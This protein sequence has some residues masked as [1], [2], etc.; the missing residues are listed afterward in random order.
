MKSGLFALA[1]AALFWALAWPSAARAQ[2]QP[3][4]PDHAAA[5]AAEAHGDSHGGHGAHDPGHGNAQAGLENMAE[6]R[7]DLALYT[8]VVFL[9]LL[10][11]LSAGAWPKI[12]RAL[13]EREQRIEADLAAAEAKHEEAKRLLAQH[14]AKLASAAAEVRALLEEARRDAEVAREQILDEAR[15][16]AA[17]VRERAVRDIEYAADHAMKNLA[18]TSANLAVELAGKVIRETINPAKAQELVRTALTKL[19]VH[20]N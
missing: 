13:L 9:L 14:E 12:S 2:E 4:A 18:E 19:N 6:F 8:F 1:T 7:T 15:E 17:K 5:E 10:A 11:I 3:A 16:S 20:N